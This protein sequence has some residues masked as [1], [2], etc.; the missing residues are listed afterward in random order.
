[1]K[2]SHPTWGREPALDEPK[3]DMCA[4]LLVWLLVGS[5]TTAT[6]TLGLISFI[7]VFGK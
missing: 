2:H 7:A 4:T 3:L 1:M 5:L 6:V